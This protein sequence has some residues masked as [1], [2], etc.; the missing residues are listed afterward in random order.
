TTYGLLDAW[1]KFLVFYGQVLRE[2]GGR[3]LVIGLL[4]FLVIAL[5]IVSAR[6]GWSG[7]LTLLAVM[8]ILAVLS[9]MLLPALA[10][11]KAKAQR[12]SSVNNLKQIGLAAQVFAND[13]N[14]RLPLSF[15]EMKNELGADKVTYDPETGQRYTY[16]GGG[17]SLDELQPDS[18]LAYS[19][20]IKGHCEV[21]YADG[22]VAQM[23]DGKFSQLSQRGL[24]LLATPPQIAEKRQREAVT[25]GQLVSP[26]SAN[27][28]PIDHLA[29]LPRFAAGISG[30]KAST[31]STVTAK[32]VMGGNDE[33]SAEAPAVAGIRSLRIELPQTGQPFLFT[34]VL[35]IR[36]E[37]L[38]IRARIMPLQTFQT[39]QM[40]WQSAAFLLG[41][42]GWWWQWRPAHRNTFILT[43]ALALILGSVGSLLVQWRA[44][45]EAL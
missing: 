24:V 37:P 1:G 41:L 33:L 34:K 14:D 8:A 31:A 25:R 15:D 36:D 19:P 43:V 21:L 2:A 9:A 32:P 26:P 17:R 28:A 11:A 4:A 6:H 5:V 39:I 42:V 35:N 27:G 29:G 13:N 40:A 23:T 18:V 38:S 45:H 3:I 12:I 30:T 20:I 16:L 7:I 44:L 22:S 10:R